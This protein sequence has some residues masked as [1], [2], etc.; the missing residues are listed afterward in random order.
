MV[1]LSAQG[2]AAA[3]DETR[4]QPAPP[5]DRVGFPR[6]Y[7][8]HFAVLPQFSRRANQVITVFGNAVNAVIAKVRGVA[9]VPFAERS[10]IVLEVAEATMDLT[11]K[12]L[13]E[14]DGIS[15]KS[16][17]NALH[18]MRRGEGVGEAYAN[19]RAGNWGFTK[20]AAVGGC[21]MAGK[22]HCFVVRGRLP[23]AKK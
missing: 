15:K 16:E 6:G 5:V 4:P 21:I 7:Q 11:N 1:A 14:T 3:A 19:N 2:L 13:G 10:A 22:E 20:Y 23:E 18:V 8:N 9:E 12:P 17:G